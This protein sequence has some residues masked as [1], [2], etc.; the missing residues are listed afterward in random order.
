MNLAAA[1]LAQ[2]VDWRSGAVGAANSGAN[3]ASAQVATEQVR[4]RLLAYA[5]QGVAPNQAVWVGLELAH[6]PQWHTYWQNP[7]DA[8]LPTQLQWTLPEGVS[9]GAIAWP[10][11]EKISL[12]PPSYLTN[13]GYEGTVLL[14]V[15]LTIGPTF[16]GP[17][18]DVEVQANWLVCKQECIPQEARLR[19]QIP[20]QSS[21]A[22]HTAAFEA[23]LAAQPQT[24]A[25]VTAK[26]TLV[27]TTLQV[28]VGGLPAA[29]HGQKLE[30][31]A[32][33]EGV[34]AAGKP[35]QQAW[36][37]GAASSSKKDR[38]TAQL[39]LLDDRRASPARLP[40]VLALADDAAQKN[41][42][43]QLEIPVQGAWP[44]VANAPLPPG[45]ATPATPKP[46][47]PTTPQ[48][49]PTLGFGSPLQFWT[50]LFG[51]LLG[52]LLLNLMPCVFPVLAI[53][54]VGFLQVRERSTRLAM[55]LA[56]TAGVVLSF[57]ALAALLLVLRATGQQLGWG[58]QLQ[59][60]AVVVAMAVLFTLLGLNLM[61][62]FAFG[63]W[64]PSRLASLQVRSHWLQAFFSGVLA[65]AIASPCT[66]PFMGAALGF[67]LGLPAAQAL[68]IFAAMGSGM[69][70]PYLAASS[71]PKLARAMPPSGPWLLVF[72]QCMALPLFATVV[73][74]VWVLGQ[75]TGVD[76][77]SA[78]LGLLV[79][80]AWVCWSLTLR[81]RTRI[82]IA[83]CLI[84]LS[85][86]FAWAF[87]GNMLKGPLSLSAP[88]LT[89]TGE[90]AARWQAWTPE[91]LE[92]A[93]TQ[94]RNVMVDFTAAWCITCQYNKKTTLQNSAVLADL[95]AHNVLLL[96]ADWTRRDPAITAALAQLGRS[97]VPTYAIYQPGQAPVLLPEVLW[98]ADV[99]QALAALKPQRP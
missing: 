36:E 65:T 71:A 23:A 7:G 2:V 70:L 10:R 12:G 37:A 16:K 8:G 5:P 32:Q 68:L 38:W 97:G 11:P 91:R 9:A 64:L 45:W 98:P 18:L 74:L 19:L 41:K 27:G 25:G 43:L 60:P 21:S 89:T 81:S 48:V 44:A 3:S 57:L 56:Y 15:P 78:L 52:G 75:Q 94:G 33:I 51:A 49:S 69:A 62:L 84:A 67:A 40:V 42:A 66:A 26:A 90:G 61:G 6:A 72:K 4:V 76:G 73:W 22:L 95:A 30:L 59:S 85:A 46:G 54:M 47:V 63:Q 55:G 92:Q 31:F 82:W 53:K 1:Q 20:A 80:L 93:L 34:L 24:L 83:A 88:E 17:Y 58:F 87:G 14:P 79:L 39:P 13:Y 96:R 77:A 50:A 86:L 35:W 28:A 99:R 29:W